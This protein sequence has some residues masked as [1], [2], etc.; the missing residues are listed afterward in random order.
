FMPASLTPQSLP[1]GVPTIAMYFS[2][3]MVV[4][5]MRAGLYQ[6]KNGLLVFLGSLRSRKSMTLAEISSSAVS[7]RF[8]VIGASSL[9]VWFAS[10]RPEGVQAITGRG[11]VMQSVVSGSTAPGTSARPRTGVFLQGGTMACSVGALLMS[12]KLTPCI[13]S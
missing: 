10:V 6:T 9:H 8:S 7:E 3:S 11:G 12:G 5:C 1:P 2:D 4:I 13:A